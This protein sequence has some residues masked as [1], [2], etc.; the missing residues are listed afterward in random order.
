[1]NGLQQLSWLAEYVV[2]DDR[3]AGNVTAVGVGL[4][5]VLLSWFLL[6][7]LLA[8]AWVALR[9]LTQQPAWLQAGVGVYRA[10]QRWLW[11]LFVAAS[12]GTL[13]LGIVYHALGGDVGHD[14]Q[15]AYRQ[16]TTQHLWKWGQTLCLLTIQVLVAWSI[17]RS[18][19]FL[20]PVA[21]DWTVKRLRRA[22]R[23]NEEPETPSVLVPQGM[24]LLERYAAAATI[25]LSLLSAGWLLEI[26]T[27][28]NPT[29]GFALRVTSILV[30]ARV[31]TL[32]FQT[33]AKPLTGYGNRQF[34]QGRLTHYWDRLARLLPLGQRCFEMAVYISAAALSVREL[35]FVEFAIKYGELVASYGDKIVKCIGIFFGTR[36]LIELLQVLLN[37][38]FGLYREGERTSQQVRTLVPLLH[39]VSQY[40][41]YV[42]GVIWMLIVFGFPAQPILAGAGILGLAVGLG[43]QSLVTDVVSG[44]FILFENQFLVGDFI[45]VGSSKG[46]VEAIAVRHTQIRDDQGKL[47]IIPNGQIKSVINSSKGFIFAV[48]DVKVPSGHDLEAHLRAMA[49]A[50]R[51][52]RK[53]HS[54]VLADTTIQ[55]LVGLTLQETT[56]R[57]VTK[58]KP[59][60][61]QLMENEYRRILK[62]IL[63]QMAALPTDRVAA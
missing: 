17:L 24:N 3:F 56:I 11:W 44:L 36:V 49:D 50:G 16:I 15:T 51:Q 62:G 42:G 47:H 8:T 31:L 2:K 23:E 45:E 7:N 1:M 28:T 6:K 57:A 30:V 38:S 59:G 19:R 41:A 29:L 27:L 14:I 4:T 61:H 60:T 40:S 9:R 39:S 35:Q 58:V 43:A 12:C 33:F 63:D 32:A 21:E 18:I 13:V 54:E 34:R 26:G 10:L 37:E 22:V 5:I 52:L 46:I 25:L 20:R 55:G 48:V 53:S